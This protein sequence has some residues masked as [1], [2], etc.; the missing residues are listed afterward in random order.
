MALNESWGFALALNEA[1][2][3]GNPGLSASRKRY[4]AVRKYDLS[5]VI[6]V[7]GVVNLWF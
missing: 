4:R 3:A 1:W 5:L 6:H 7:F 2:G